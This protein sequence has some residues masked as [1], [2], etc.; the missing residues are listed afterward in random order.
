MTH[1]TFFLKSTALCQEL[2]CALSSYGPTLLCIF[3]LLQTYYDSRNRNSYLQPVLEDENHLQ[4]TSDCRVFLRPVCVSSLCP[5][6][7][8]SREPPQP[9]LQC[10]LDV[11]SAGSDFPCNTSFASLVSRNVFFI[12]SCSVTLFQVCLL[13]C[14]CPILLNFL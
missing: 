3:L 5:S 7:F 8:H 4:F 6:A 9:P 1:L 11:P 10:A 12:C 13:Y 2:P 14:T